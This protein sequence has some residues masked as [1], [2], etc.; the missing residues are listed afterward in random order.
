MVGPTAR[1]RGRAAQSNSRHALLSRGQV[2]M[3]GG[4]R[5]VTKEVTRGVTWALR[6]LQ[7]RRDFV[8]AA[9]A[10]IRSVRRARARM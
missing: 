6:R 4:A 2:V 9:A 5:G 7:R 3:R 1:L 10:A 8:E